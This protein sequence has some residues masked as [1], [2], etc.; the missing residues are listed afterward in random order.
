MSEDQNSIAYWIGNNIVGPI[1]L[2][3]IFIFAFSLPIWSLW[4]NIMCYIL[5]LLNPINFWQSVGL[6]TLVWC[7][8]RVWKGVLDGKK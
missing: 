3:I 7:F 8:G 5:P 2:A 6:C 4:N 1:F